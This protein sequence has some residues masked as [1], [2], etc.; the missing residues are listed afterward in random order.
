M[1]NDDDGKERRRDKKGVYQ[2]STRL[3][4]HVLHA[5]GVVLQASEVMS[6]QAKAVSPFLE[7]PGAAQYGSASA[8]QPHQAAP[9]QAT[10]DQARPVAP[11]AKLHAAYAAA[12]ANPQAAFVPNAS[13]P[14][15]PALSGRS[16][17]KNGSF[18]VKVEFVGEMDDSGDWTCVQP[19]TALGSSMEQARLTA[20]CD[21]SDGDGA[22]EVLVHKTLLL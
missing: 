22:V 8:Q 2:H 7:D 16:P 21:V 11:Q 18:D 6:K 17:D 10:P 5:V 3:L 19:S 4:L 14:T 20:S 12:K 1:F 9:V 13:T 15:P